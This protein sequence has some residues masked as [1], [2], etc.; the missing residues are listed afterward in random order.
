MQNNE[1]SIVEAM[2]ACVNQQ[3]WIDNC[4]LV[5]AMNNGDYPAWWNKAIIE[6]GIYKEKQKGWGSNLGFQ[7][8]MPD[9]LDM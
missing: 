8:L 6:S 4:N 3:E 7:T 1:V 5:K 9:F 2:K